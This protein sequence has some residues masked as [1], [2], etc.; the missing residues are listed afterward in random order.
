MFCSLGQ[1][2]SFVHFSVPIYN[3]FFEKLDLLS[4]SC[5]IRLLLVMHH[6]ISF[7]VGDMPNG[8]CKGSLWCADPQNCCTRSPEQMCRPRA[9]VITLPIVQLNFEPI[10][11]AATG[12]WH[13]K[14]RAQIKGRSVLDIGH[15]EDIDKLFFSFFNVVS[16]LLQ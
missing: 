1:F 15:I 11:C 8:G 13:L 2:K 14:V 12:L 6:H 5:I 7:S 4:M 3:I 16:F 10:K 9:Q